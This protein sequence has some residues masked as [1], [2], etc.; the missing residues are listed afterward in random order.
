[1]EAA[2]ASDCA[3]L[4][5][6]EALHTGSVRGGP[7][8]SVPEVAVDAGRGIVGDRKYGLTGRGS[9]LTLIAA[10]G[11]EQMVGETQIPLRPAETRR[12]VL[13]RQGRWMTPHLLGVLDERTA[14]RPAPRPPR[15][16]AAAS[17]VG[18]S[19]RTLNG[20]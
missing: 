8:D 19:V 1:M 10:E 13:T 9:N 2:T 15:L 4:G 16:C 5:R 7:I 14:A 6:V 18:R 12:N 20:L 17:L 3:A 11:I